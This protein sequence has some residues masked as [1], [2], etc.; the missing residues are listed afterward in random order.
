MEELYCQGC[1]AA[2]Q[3]EDETK[4]GFAPKSALQRD[5]VICKRCFRLKHYNEVQDV[6]MTADDFLNMLQEIEKHDALIVK[7]VD[8]F[9]VHG[10]FIHGLNRF[11]GKNPVVLVANKVDL[12]PKSINLN[13][14]KKWMYRVAKEFGLKVNDIFFV[15]ATKGIG[16]Q[17]AAFELERL[18]DGKDVFVVGSTNVGKSTIINY[19]IQNSNDEKDVITTSYFPGT[20]LGFIDIPLD[21]RSSMIDTPGIMN[22]HQMAHYLNDKDLKTITPKKEVKPKV[23]QLDEDQTLFIGGLARF[24]IES[25]QERLGYVCYFSNEIN[26]HRT[27]LEKADLLYD[28]HL[29][30]MLSPPSEEALDNW[31]EMEERTLKISEDKTDV[32]FS[33]LGWI[34]VPN[35]GV[36]ITAH[37]P[38]GV[39]VILREAII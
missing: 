33:G 9:D 10:S 24:D 32:L 36:T 19:F 26:I 2:I 28:Q 16:M 3:T 18:R 27:K 5:E 7:V 13:K 35:A 39:R 30:E 22:H 17:E 11:V 1:G 37:V 21:E 23:F 34:T 29:G 38:K 15:S 31:P 25:A 6:D 4:A 12:L 20:T 14:V 8:L